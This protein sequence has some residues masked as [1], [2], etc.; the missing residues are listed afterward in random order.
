MPKTITVLLVRLCECEGNVTERIGS[1]GKLTAL[2]RRQ[3]QA[4]R[5]RLTGLRVAAWFSADNSACRETA[6]IVADGRPITAMRE[7]N[8][9]PFPEWKGKTL[10]EV[11][12]QRP[13][14]WDGY[15]DP[16][17]GTASTRI[18]PGGESLMETCERAMNGLQ[19]VYE[20]CKEVGNVGIVTHGEIVRLVPLALLQAP[21]ESMFRLRG[22]NGAVTIF[23]FDGTRATF[24][25]LNDHRHLLE[26]GTKDLRDY[27][28][29]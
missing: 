24:V 22:M 11:R 19:Q 15:F 5:D 4:T 2:G 25:C 3:A 9:A 26:L 8:E 28:K 27:S 14:E 13:D 16:K 7:F 12:E 18:I 29:A 23:E 21:L 6:E 20:R 10:K 1:H 17:P